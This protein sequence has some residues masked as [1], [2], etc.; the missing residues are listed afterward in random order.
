MIKMIFS[1]I[2]L[3][4]VSGYS[5]LQLNT[6]IL[7]AEKDLNQEREAL[8]LPNGTALKVLSFGY[9]NLLANILWFN[10]I[11]YFGKH[12][13]TD[14]NYKWLAHMCDL[15]SELNPIA[16][17]VYEFCSTMLSWEVNKAEDAVQVLNKAI[18]HTPNYWRY[19]YLR[20]FI[21]FYFL[22]NSELAEK[23]FKTASNKPDA[24]PFVARLAA[25]KMKASDPLEAI[26]FLEEMIKNS[27]DISQRSLLEDKLRSIKE[28]IK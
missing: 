5:L 18:K 17:H 11:N 4:T 23:D 6:F 16:E 9:E 24:P 1:I 3:S 7:P 21:Y 19:Y 20:G 14:R 12:Y 26:R 13:K 25:T 2:I 10:T 27:E 28:E 8:Y 15:V 22:D